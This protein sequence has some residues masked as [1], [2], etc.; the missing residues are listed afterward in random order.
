[1]K[2]LIVS[3][4]IPE[5]SPKGDTGLSMLRE[6]LG[7]D[8]EVYWATASDLR[9]AENQLWIRAR[10]I[11]SCQEAV[12]PQADDYEEGLRVDA[13]DGLWIRKDPPFDGAYQSLCWLLALVEAEVPMINPPSCLLRF[14]EKLLPYEALR[15]GFIKAEELIPTY[16]V[17]G[18]DH[19]IQPHFTSDQIITKPWMGHGG[20]SVE[21][22]P[23]L[24]EA[25]NSALAPDNPFTLIQPFISSVRE[26]GD[27]RVLF[28]NGDYCGDVVRIP[29]EDSILANLV[30]GAKAESRPM[31][32]QEQDLTKRVGQ[33]LKSIGMLLAGAD[34]ID[35]RLTEINITA[36]TG[37]EAVADVGQVN[38]RGKYLD[39][40]EQLAK[41]KS[42]A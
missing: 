40:A 20:R 30:Q 18:E 32:E 34:Y 12:L 3:D 6:A 11:Q 28:I 35:G 33:F 17:T 42:H 19:Q 24:D 39:L 10:R 13:F 15:R 23:N 5:L 27:R 2:F 16:M 4:P 26:Q 7:R 1:M 8:H 14:H 22:W 9:L 31:T 38:P 25:M 41:N 37:F 29:P 21:C 36:P